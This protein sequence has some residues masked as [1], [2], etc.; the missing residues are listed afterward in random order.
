[1]TRFAAC[2]SLLAL[3]LST[4]SCRAQ[5][6]ARNEPD[7]DRR[8]IRH[9][10]VERSY[11]LRMP[12][13]QS[14]TGRTIPL[15]IVLHGGGGNAAYAESMTGFTATARREGF[16]VVYPDGTGPRRNV[17]LTWNAGH[18]CGSSM[19]QRVDDVGFIDA[20]IT[21]LISS[22]PIDSRRVYVTGMSNGG[23]MTH[24]VGIELSHRIAAIAP[25]VGAVFG[26]EPRPRA[27]VSAIMING[28]TDRSV[29][30]GGGAPGGRFSRAWDGTPTKP[31]ADQGRFWAAANGC[32]VAAQ[33]VDRG[34][35]LHARH[36]CR[37]GAIDVELYALKDEGH[38]W[39]GGE[40][41]S[42]LGDRPSS[43]F[44]ATEVIW[45]FFAAHS[46]GAGGLSARP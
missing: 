3:V 4:T 5:R 22:H 27:Q 37:S 16:A 36:A 14:R 25:V 21:E 12:Q 33:S 38:S 43:T 7:V 20:L 1:M 24:R 28:M 18:C 23:M 44:D 31:A 32:D 39:P 26:D 46:K 15:V 34:T 17:M 10:G 6:P 9:A 29:P 2:T 35:Y 11:V 13:R 41:G 8:T 19:T 30:Y 45:R 42:R 40:R